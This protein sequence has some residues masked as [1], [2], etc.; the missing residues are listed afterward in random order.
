[1][2]TLASTMACG[3]AEESR[4]L[5]VVTQV[6]QAQPA[7]QVSAGNPTQVDTP[8]PVRAGLQAPVIWEPTPAVPVPGGECGMSEEMDQLS[9][10][11]IRADQEWVY[12]DV[13]HRSA[14]P[15]DEGHP[16]APAQMRVSVDGCAYR[17]PRV[18]GAVWRGWSTPSTLTLALADLPDGDLTVMASAHGV[19]AVALLQK[20]GKT[21]ASL[22]GDQ[23]KGY[24]VIPGDPARG[25]EPMVTIDHGRDCGKW[26]PP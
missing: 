4:R 17:A 14:G 11:Q 2:V 1:V 26:G 23:R 15:E 8:R 22:R 9:F 19:E 12:L 24:R 3:A 7:L 13:E 18:S 20:Q 5:E 25:I 6:A 21:L 16:G 10:T